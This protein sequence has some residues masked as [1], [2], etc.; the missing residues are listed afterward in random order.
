MPRTYPTPGTQED[1][2]L[3]VLLEAD[4]AWVNKQYFV[5]TLYLTQAGRALHNLEH[6]HHWKIEHSDFR[7]AHNFMSYRIAPEGQPSLFMS[8][9]AMA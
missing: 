2:V 3:R 8:Q 1:R 4:G 9:I 7:D 5:R 6:K